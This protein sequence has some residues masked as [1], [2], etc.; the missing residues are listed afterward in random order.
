MNILKQHIKNWLIQY[1]FNM[2]NDSI[3]NIIRQLGISYQIKEWLKCIQKLK[4]IW[5][6]LIEYIIAATINGSLFI[7]AFAIYL[8]LFLD[9]YNIISKLLFIFN[10]K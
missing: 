2:G 5:P 4:C 1:C 6:N 7:A 8:W 3:K 10:D 9:D